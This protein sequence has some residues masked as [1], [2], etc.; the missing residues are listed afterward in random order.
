MAEI[1]RQSLVGEVYMTSLLRAQLRLAVIV[2]VAL[3]VTVGAL[4]LVFLQFPGL[5]DILVLGMPLPWVMLAFGIYPVLVVLGWLYV[6]AAERNEQAFAD[7]V[8]RS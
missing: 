3:T 4:P 5:N 8:E 1:D 6:R 2:L 7:V